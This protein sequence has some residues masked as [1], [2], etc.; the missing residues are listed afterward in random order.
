M[1]N[2]PNDKQISGTCHDQ[3]LSWIGSKYRAV[4]GCVITMMLILF[5]NIVITNWRILQIWDK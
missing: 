2:G 3:W 4:L 1:F 5:T